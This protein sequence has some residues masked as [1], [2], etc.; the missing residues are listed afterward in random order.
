MAPVLRVRKLVK[1]YGGILATDHVD[2]AV[3]AHEI[4]ALI[5]PNGAGKTSFVNQL[6]GSLRSDA[7][8]IEFHGDEI[9]RMPIHDRVKAGV[10][11]SHQITSVFKNY[12]VLHNVLLAV[13]ARSGSSFRFTGS[14]FDETPLIDAARAVIATV[15]LKGMEDVLARSLSHGEQRRVEIALAL[16]TDPKLLLLDEPL[17]GMGSADAAS[18]VE[19]IE[20]LKSRLTIVLVEH[21][22]NAV[23]RL[24]DRI[25]VLVYGKVIATDVPSAIRSS[26]AVKKAYLGEGAVA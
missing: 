2:L 15:G 12:T 16:A 3:D 9:S 24:A 11:R 7:G 10:A 18:M 21:D 26:P 6:A 13:Q 5:G 22:M 17:A 19:L 25:T 20:A 23:F 14:P 1:R 4:H 8:S